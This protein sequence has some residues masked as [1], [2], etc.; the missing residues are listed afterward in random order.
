MRSIGGPS[1]GHDYERTG[2]RASARPHGARRSPVVAFGLLIYH[3]LAGR[4]RYEEWCSL[5]TV[6]QFTVE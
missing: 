6:T 3:V 2:A 5:A 1:E 4:V